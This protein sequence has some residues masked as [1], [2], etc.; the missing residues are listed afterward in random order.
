MQ[1]LRSA[2]IISTRGTFILKNR[3][4]NCP[5]TFFMNEREFADEAVRICAL[6]MAESART[7]PKSRGIDDLEIF[8]I[9]KERI[10]EIA[11]K[12][13][14]FASEDKDFLRDANSIRKARGILVIGVNGGKPIGVNCGACG[15]KSCAEFEKARR[16][17]R[18]FRGPNCAFKLID[19]GIA[20]GSAAKVS[21]ILGVDTRIMYRAAI[22][23]K[24]LGI[25]KSDVLFAIPIASEGKNP[26]FD[27]QR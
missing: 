17:E 20:L 23:I 4:I 13:E 2:R 14:E 6:I 26:F 1:P 27:R 12:M 21:S 25:V 19:L 24:Q 9:G 8:Y 15:F 18:K 5:T 11:K 7:A 22:A 3:K 16:E 10:E